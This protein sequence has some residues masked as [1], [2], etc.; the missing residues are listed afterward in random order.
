MHSK[1][2]LLESGSL[3]TWKTAVDYHFYHGLGILVLGMVYFSKPSKLLRLAIIFLSLGIVLFS[4]SLYLLCTAGWSWLGPVT[5]LGGLAFIAGWI[6]A[7]PGLKTS[8][9]HA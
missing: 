4:G 1:D 7:I 5:P 6:V 2:T 9:Q 8:L 3:E